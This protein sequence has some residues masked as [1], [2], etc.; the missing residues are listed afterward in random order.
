MALVESGALLPILSGLVLCT[1][2]ITILNSFLISTTNNRINVSPGCRKDSECDDGDPCTTN[3]CIDDVCVYTWKNGACSFDYQCGENKACED[4]S[5]T[6][7]CTMD[8]CILTNVC[9]TTSCF[10]GSCEI[11][12][13]DYGCCT[14]DSECDDDNE[15]TVDD[16]NNHTCTNTIPDG[17]CSKSSDCF[18]PNEEC[19]NCE[20]VDTC[21]GVTCNA[22]PCIVYECVFGTCVARYTI[23]GCCTANSDC[24]D[25]DPCTQNTCGSDRHCTFQV[26]DGNC[27]LDVDCKDSNSVCTDCECEDLCD[28]VD[29]TT[30]PCAVK[31]CVMG[32]CETVH[33]IPGCCDSD[34][35]CSDSITCTV[36]ECTDNNTCSHS[37][38]VDGCV[39][40]A[41]CLSESD[42]CNTTTC[43][44]VDACQ[45]IDC[46]DDPCVVKECRRG[47]CVVLHTILGCCTSDSHCTE[48]PNNCTVATCSN[49]STCTYSSPASPGCAKSSDCV[50]LG[51]NYE[52][53]SC[54]CTDL[55]D[56]STIDCL[57]EGDFSPCIVRNC[58]RGVCETLHTIPGCCTE[59]SHCSDGSTCT[60]DTCSGNNTCT[61][62]VPDGSCARDS[63]CTSDN[64]ICTDC[65]CVDLCDGVDCTI[66][67]N[68]CNIRECRKGVCVS[69][70]NVTDCC[71]V[72][73][74][75]PGDG[76]LCTEDSCIE[77]ICFYLPTTGAGGCAR[78]SDCD[79]NHVCN[80]TTCLCAPTGV[81]SCTDS[82]D[83][84]DS[85][86]C[87]T[88]ICDAS[89][90]C[91]H[92]PVLGCCSDDSDCES[93]D[94]CMVPT[95][96]ITFGTCL[97]TYL[98]SDS[99]GIK[100]P[101]DC[102]DSNNTIGYSTKYFEDSDDD[103]Y[104]VST[105]LKYSCS[106]VAGYAT[107][108][109]D[110][111]DGDVNV[112][113][114]SVAC[115]STP[116]GAGTQLKIPILEPSFGEK[117][118][119]SLDLS[120][121]LIVYTSFNNSEK[122]QVYTAKHQNP[123]RQLISTVT[124]DDSLVTVNT[125][126]SIFGTAV[127][128]NGEYL[129]VT[130][131]KANTEG[132][133]FIYNYTADDT[134]PWVLRSGVENPG[135]GSNGFGLSV[136]VHKM[137]LNTDDNSNV[138]LVGSPKF[139]SSE[140]EVVAVDID[141]IPP[142]TDVISNPN[143]TLG[144]LFGCS[145]SMNGFAAVIGAPGGSCE[146]IDAL[147]E[148]PPFPSDAGAAYLYSY[149]LSA[150]TWSM[151]KQLIPDAGAGSVDGTA[152]GRSVA[153]NKDLTIMAVGAPYYSPSGRV[154]IFKPEALSYSEYCT[155]DYP[156]SDASSLFGYSLSIY[157][158][159]LLI[160]APSSDGSVGGVSDQGMA[161]LYKIGRNNKCY[162]I[163]GITPYEIQTSGSFGKALSYHGQKMAIGAPTQDPIGNTYITECIQKVDCR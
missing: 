52:C 41:D 112:F 37:V 53:V 20:C 49:N 97:V 42:Q 119:R 79:A 126:I 69:L 107:E 155:I 34:A 101:F 105:S 48:T 62:T 115:S 29:C 106:T 139:S 40:D 67:G 44:C 156:L 26:P 157:G 102:D 77:N 109:G 117:Y 19:E 110:C 58:V 81:N 28:G 46:M 70:H 116:S 59:D 136:D 72:D 82:D 12:A 120:G 150:E 65:E 162:L 149:D 2:A 108:S 85:N 145:V 100:C 57:T 96:Q 161:F 32:T 103:G 54:N 87:T 64:E 7:S 22:N 10:G 33:T 24:D 78:H 143:A 30:D 158:D 111:D 131:P 144:M 146:G 118:G 71:I 1:L 98:D 92:F 91:F 148:S 147:L 84:D 51:P 80:F 14:S 61:Y 151:T 11:I 141:D 55:C 113:P 39:V 127:A 6:E 35:D 140:G 104:G 9:Q 89:N 3:L 135:T 152:F 153:L 68:P 133:V 160:G 86:D 137:G 99:D 38:P 50:D 56:P 154:Y 45:A 142:T 124:Q 76:N 130:A 95:C 13:T 60:N 4:C 47:T 25:S 17:T 21:E 74:D 134:D 132:M 122:G 66:V 23:P 90:K 75:C 123:F 159:T 83:C 15:C 129:V 121:D 128:T 8:E 27:T 36:D 163:S 114:G 73:A 94:P 93:D 5:C 138:V 18:G 43:E 31:I 88:D 125:D 63:D 16:C